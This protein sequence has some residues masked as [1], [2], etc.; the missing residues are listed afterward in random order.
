MPRDFDHDWVKATRNRG[1]VNVHIPKGQLEQFDSI[2]A[3]AEL[4]VKR[5]VPYSGRGRVFLN[6]REVPEEDG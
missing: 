4:E 2:D 6:F 3:E 1:G 5:Y